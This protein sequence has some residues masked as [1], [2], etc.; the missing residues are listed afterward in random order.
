[1]ATPAIVNLNRISA[2]VT[3]STDLNIMFRQRCQVLSCQ[4]KVLRLQFAHVSKMA[5]RINKL[6]K[7]LK[8]GVSKLIGKGSEEANEVQNAAYNT[9]AQLAI[10]CPTV[11][12][13]SNSFLPI[14]IICHRNRSNCIRPIRGAFG[15]AQGIFD[16]RKQPKI[17]GDTVLTKGEKDTVMMTEDD[18]SRIPIKSVV[19]I[20]FRRGICGESAQL[21]ERM[22]TYL[23]GVSKKEH[24]NY[25]STLLTT[26]NNRQRR[27]SPKICSQLLMNHNGLCF[28]VSRVRLNVL[29]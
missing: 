29:L 4:C 23:F 22:T 6:F 21:K 11:N 16:W 19:K 24:P 13:M 26:V 10:V 8:T 2:Y 3:V 15:R 12:T 7:T 14:L 9:L 5:S 1:M 28:R 25:G 18:S 17:P 20:L 27:I